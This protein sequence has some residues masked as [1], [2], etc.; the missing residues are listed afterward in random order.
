MTLP[1]AVPDLPDKLAQRAAWDQA[2]KEQGKADAKELVSWANYTPLVVVVPF[3]NWMIDNWPEWAM[4]SADGRG[5][6]D[7]HN[8]V[9]PI[10]AFLTSD[11][12]QFD[13]FD[14]DLWYFTRRGERLWDVAANLTDL[15]KTGDMW[16]G[17]IFRAQPEAF[18]AA[19]PWRVKL[20]EDTPL[21]ANVSLRLP[22]YLAALAIKK[23]KLPIVQ[24]P[25]M[26]NSQ[27]L[28]WAKGTANLPKGA[29]LRSGSPGGGKVMQGSG[30]F[31]GSKSPEGGASAAEPGVALLLVAGII[32]VTLWASKRGGR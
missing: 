10:A 12:A 2:Q 1:Q 7:F 5:E 14:G 16:S 17:W 32:G 13:L 23:Y 15:G 31:Q 24:A 20:W 6:S 21:P 29:S 11:P 27:G 30:K 3:V 22:G 8:T 26:A 18:Q 25:T 19:L 28:A 4:S 9:N